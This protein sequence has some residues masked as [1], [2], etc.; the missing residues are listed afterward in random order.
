MTQALAP[1]LKQDVAGFEVAD[2]TQLPTPTLALDGPAIRRNIERLANYSSDVG[3]KIRPH[4]KTHKSRFLA[5]LQLDAGACGITCAKVSEVERMSEPGQD[6][7]LAYPPVGALRAERLAALARDRTVRAAVDTVAA[8][9]AASEA[10]RAANVTMGLLVD[11]DVGMGRTGV[12]SPAA[13]LALAQAIDRAPGLRLDG[14]MIYP[15][16]IWEPADQQATALKA[17]SDLVA[18]TLELWVQHGLAAAIVSGGSTPTAYQSHLIGNLTE[19]RPGTYIF[20]DMNTVDGGFCKLEDCAARILATV[21]SDAVSGQVVIDAGSKTL[22]ND[23]N[24]SAPDN[25]FGHIVEYPHT[26]I[27]RLSEEHGQVDITACD[28]KPKVGERVTVIPNHICPCVNLRDTVWWSEPNEPLR[29]L[30]VDARGL[31]Q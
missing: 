17:V 18:K 9:T 1:S 7:L 11:L 5:A 4:T 3:I 25:G 20:N 29:E 13:A 19:I 26:R 15:G 22:T 30:P 21:I 6:V 2:L 27:R 12:E 24:I 16:H 28:R 8:V 14:I 31:I 10:A 23:R